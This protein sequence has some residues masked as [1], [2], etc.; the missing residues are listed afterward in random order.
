MNV[1]VKGLAKYLPSRIET[2]EDLAKAF[3][4][5]SVDKIFQKTGISSRHISGDHEFASDLGTAAARALIE[6]FEVSP[7]IFDY[8]LLVT[9]SADFYLPTTACM[10][11]DALGMR[12][13]AGAL[14]INLGCSGFVAGLGLA[15]GLIVSGQA[16]N[17]LLITADTYT[18]FINPQDKAVRTIFGD[19]ASAAWIS[20]EPASASIGEF[21]YGTDGSGARHLI[22]PNGS[23]RPGVE[24][25]PKSQVENR[26]EVSNG[27]DLFMDGAEIFNFTLRIAEDAVSEI[28]RKN[29][30]RIEDV[31][32]FVFHQANAFMLKHLQAKLQ[33][34]EDR[35]VVVMS[36]WG[37]TVSSTI[38]MALLEL[39]NQ[40]ALKAG[41]RVLI[42]GFGVGLSWAGSIITV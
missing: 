39:E 37:N 7:E 18:K 11:H 6:K 28:L 10:I 40:N 35:F 17:V 19:G 29:D 16:Q 36:E 33:L 1:S 22:V 15:K 41:D 42:L 13:D 27:F 8:V 14:D 30:L 5:W 24:I 34:P 9:Q 23:I 31:A 38:P 32:H 26:F 20:S 21:V 4:E 3:P 2:N 12:T 25:A